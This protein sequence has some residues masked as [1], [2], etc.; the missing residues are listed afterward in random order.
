M[1]SLQA[2]WAL[3]AILGVQTVTDLS[4][5]VLARRQTALSRSLPFLVSGAAGVLL[6]TAC[7]DLL[8]ESVQASRGSPHV[9]QA[10]LLGLLVLFCI[11]AW[12]HATGHPLPA[13]EERMSVSAVASIAEMPTHPGHGRSVTPLL[14][15]SALHSTVD[16]VA[17]AAAFA[18]GRKTGCSAALAV[19]LHEMPHRV[20]DFSLLVHRG[21]PRRRAAELAIGAG[22]MAIVGGLFVV[23]LGQHTAAAPW[24]LPISA[25]T[26]L[27]I[28]L[29]DLIPEVHARHDGSWVG[30]KI[31]CLLGGAGLI[32]LLTLL[33]GE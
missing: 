29:A 11:E 24:L 23:A 30:W 27:Y 8:P 16:G 26:F 4:V 1:S 6:A 17:I 9:W 3:F 12:A 19:A 28:A 33:P 5:V 20:G 32:A 7:L 2:L 13:E 10:L 15:G 14:L 25:A 18:A 21:M 31:A 22:A